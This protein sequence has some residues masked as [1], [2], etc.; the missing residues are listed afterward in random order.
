MDEQQNTPSKKDVEKYK[1][2]QTGEA[3]AKEAGEKLLQA[4]GVPAPIANMAV[5]KIAEDPMIKNAINQVSNKNLVTRKALAAAA[6]TVNQLTGAE[7]NTPDN[8]SGDSSSGTNDPINSIMNK[9]DQAKEMGQSG[10]DQI[11]SGIK[12]I[13]ANPILRLILTPPGVFIFGGFLA[14]MLLLFIII[15]SAG[16][17]SSSRSG[18]GL[19]SIHCGAATTLDD[20]QVQI[21]YNDHTVMPNEKYDFW[22]FVM[23]VLKA[24]SDPTV[25]QWG[26]GTGPESSYYQAMAIAIASYTLGRTNYQDGDTEIQIRS[27]E[28]DLVHCDIVNGCKRV[29]TNKSCI[30][31]KESFIGANNSLSGTGGTWKSASSSDQLTMYSEIINSVKG[32]FVLTDTEFSGANFASTEWRGGST[33]TCSG[34]LEYS[35]SN[36]NPSYMC[37]NWAKEDSKDGMSYQQIIGKY[38]LN[39]KNTSWNLVTN[40][41]LTGNTN[42]CNNQNY[43]TYNGTYPIIPTTTATM[44]TQNLGTYL[45]DRNSSIDIWN[46]KISNEVSKAGFGTR[47]GVVAAAAT[48]INGLNYEYG[49]AI[50]YEWGGNQSNGLNSSWGGNKRTVTDKKNVFYYAGLDCSGFTTWALYN[51]G[52]NYDYESS[53]NQKSWG[54]EE[55]FT[56]YLAKPGDLVWKS[57]HIALIVDVQYD[58]YLIAE[59]ITPGVMISKYSLD[60][61]SSS[62]DI[63]KWCSDACSLVNMDEFYN[64]I[65][66][67]RNYEVAFK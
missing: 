53:G 44:V 52:F 19:N 30:G 3:I 37:Q 38:Y 51:G 46:S 63:K 47:D 55:K 36:P 54:K 10:V 15:L 6:P 66:K 67:I 5:N 20:L 34:R 32:N 43:G 2:A 13:Y 45:S 61:T 39:N 41:G 48:L 33:Q 17:S 26:N 40:V 14:V 11:T 16:G 50:P 23:G 9:T 18:V 62:G 65:T 64:D 58:H 21:L 35:R 59:A 12:K 7:D 4:K 24:E 22:T 1:A 8:A 49:I 42:H 57:G 25:S 28:C 56:N 29:T 31:I 27:S 60:G